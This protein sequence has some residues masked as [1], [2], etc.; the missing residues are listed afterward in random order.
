MQVASV[1]AQSVRTSAHEVRPR[2]FPVFQPWCLLR[3]I[4]L[5]IESDSVTC[6]GEQRKLGLQRS[7]NSKQF[8]LWRQTGT[9]GEG[10]RPTWPILRADVG[11]VPSPGGFEPFIN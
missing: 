2:S 11:R 8:S 3:P 6:E 7:S 1:R 9:P 10:T 4:L 5:S